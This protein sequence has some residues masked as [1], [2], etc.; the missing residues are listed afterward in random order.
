MREGVGILVST[1]VMTIEGPSSDEV[2]ASVGTPSRR[3]TVPSAH[4]LVATGRRPNTTGI[5]LEAACVRVDERGLTAID[6]PRVLR[7]NLAGGNR[8]TRG[9]QVPC[10]MFTDQ[11][12]ARIGRGE[13]EARAM[14]IA[15]RVAKLP[16]GLV[17]WARTLDETTGLMN[18]VVANHDEVLGFVMVGHEAGEVVAVVQMAILARLPSTA[19][20]HAVIAT[21]RW[22]RAWACSCPGSSLP[23]GGDAVPTRIPCHPEADILAQSQGPRT[24]I[25][26]RGAMRFN[27]RV[28]SGVGGAAVRWSRLAR[29]R[30]RRPTNCSASA[31]VNPSSDSRLP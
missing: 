9:R 21:P 14:G 5:G 24:W 30:V 10:C 29:S 8:T 23:T 2:T 25:D 11:P 26:R 27:A 7:D 22:T 15:V 19:L 18:A 28:H 1:E 17:M 20:P 3:R 12:M 16:M 6:D 4:I 31:S 13:D